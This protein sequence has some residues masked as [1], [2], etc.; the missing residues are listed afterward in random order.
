MA[1]PPVARHYARADL[2]EAILAA[3]ERSGKDIHALTPADLAPVDEFHVRGRE[4][5]EE[6][7]RLCGVRR[8]KTVLDVG[9]GLGGS[10]RYLAAEF[11]CQVTGIDLTGDYCRVGTLLN[12]RLG[13]DGLVTL[14]QGS[15]L[16]MPFPDASFDVAWTEHAQMNIADKARLYGEIARVL[17]PGGRLAFHDI[18]AGTSGPPHFP[19][20]WAEDPSISHLIAPAALRRLLDAQGLAIVHWDEVSERARAW[21]QRA[22]ERIQ[23]HGQPPLGFHLLMGQTARAKLENALRN[24]AEGRIAFVQA[25]LEKPL[26]K[27]S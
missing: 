27:P 26:D 10:A 25:V 2:F 15:A 13:L 11:G 8:G 19:V 7:A 12:E 16:D 6:L 14:R 20:P 21:Y 18:L 1:E 5:S 3:L 23:K 9:C 22:L 24:T 4:A 17:K